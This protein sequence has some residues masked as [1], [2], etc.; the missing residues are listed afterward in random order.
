[1][2]EQFLVTVHPSGDVM[3]NLTGG[4]VWLRGYYEHNQ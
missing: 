2:L 3:W 4:A 1:V